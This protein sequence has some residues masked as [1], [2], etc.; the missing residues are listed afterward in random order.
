MRAAT[1]FCVDRPLVV[2]ALMLVL[3]VA[4]GLVA[5]LPTL[6]PDTFAPLHPLRVDTDPENMLPA[7]EP[8][9]VFHNRMKKLLALHEIIVV[10]VVRPDHPEGVFTPDTLANIKALTDHAKTIEGVIDRD[11]IALSTVDNV[12]SG[13]GR[14][15]FSWLMPTAPE[16]G[17]EAV[18]VREKALDLPFLKG[19]LVADSGRAVA[20]YIPI[21]RKDQSYRIATE[22]QKTI[23][24]LDGP[25]A[26]H[27]TGLPVAQDTFGVEMFKQMAV[28]APLAML[29]IFLFMWFFFRRVALILS[30]MVVAG[31]TVVQVMGLLVASGQTVHIMSSMIPIFIMPIAV[32]DAIHILSDFFDRYQETRDRRATVL[33]VMDTLFMPML[34]TSLTTTVGFA[35]LALTP[36]PPVQIFGIFVAAGVLLAWFW[37][38]T[39]IPASIMLIPARWLENFGMAEGETAESAGSPMSRVLA[40]L[41]RFTFRHA[42]LVL[43]VTV[44]LTVVAGWGISLIRINDNP[45]KW[46]TASHP[47]READRVLNRHFAGTYMAY[48][49]LEPTE[50][51]STPAES[52]AALEEAIPERIAAAEAEELAGAAEVYADL[53]EEARRLAAGAESR[54]ALLRALS[55]YAEDR[56]VDAE[57]SYWAWDHAATFVSAF[58]QRAEFFKSPQILEWMASLQ[59]R[60]AESGLVGKSN[61]VTDLVKTVHR[62]LQDGA[63]A[64]FRIPDSQRV[65]AE[66]LLQFQNSHRPYDLWHFVTPDYRTASLWLQLKS[67]D[68]VDM[69]RVVAIVDAWIAENP[70]PEPLTHRW[71][72][73]TYINVVWQGKMVAGMLKA[74]IGSFFVV[75]LMMVILFRS[76]LWGLLSMVPLTVTIALIYGLI[77]IVGK[78]YDMPVAVLSSLSLGLAIDYAIHFLARSRALSER[79]GSWPDA[80]GDVFGEPAR[81]ISRN[82][83]V[84]GVGFLPLLLAPLVPYQT[85]GFLIAAILV[86]AGVAS[87]FI[88]PALIT[89]LRPWLFPGTEARAF[90]C[91]CGT[92]G[93]GLF[94]VGGMLLLNLYP[95]LRAHT[96]GIPVAFGVALAFVALALLACRVLS[97]RPRCRVWDTGDGGAAETGETDATA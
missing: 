29:V 65:V 44:L 89:L 85:V 94:A 25:E 80:V 15:N 75:L 2:T 96:L 11:I 69:Q 38:I 76:G 42:K 83:V 5:A 8:V 23:D 88:L 33:R 14:V 12:E 52:L 60:V 21:E 73:L 6:W 68:N 64:A 93:V 31:V 10:G 97:A 62:E 95:L 35:S 4:I 17:A 13:E 24:S 20:L 19:T 9:R 66:T 91:R 7:D 81:A 86:A 77:G 28:S 32:L 59:A 27:I 79:A 45:T 39:F 36:I 67:G 41:G 57:E 92:I 51:L 18:A 82:V 58:A 54:E 74:F 16:T 84:V 72:G 43:F 78:D 61:G 47:I 56:L 90:V 55:T 37:T 26:Y 70:P 71:F 22:L 3:T 40:V 1:R 34:Y 48:L 50:T 49:A 87:L 30:P 46:F 63:P 53:R